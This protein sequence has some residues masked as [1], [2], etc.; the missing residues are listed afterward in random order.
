[1]SLIDP[2]VREP[3]EW[4]SQGEDSDP[5]VM[6]SRVRLARNLEKH[7]FPARADEEILVRIR[8]EVTG[9]ARSIPMLEGAVEAPLE[10]LDKVERQVLVER[11]LISREHAERGRGSAVVVRPDETVSLMINEEDHIRMQSLRGGLALRSAWESIR[12][13]DDALEERLIF[14]FS[15]RLGYLTACPTNVGTGLRASV[16]L[17]LPGLVMNGEMVQVIQAVAKLGLAVR[18]LYGEGT[19]AHGNLFQVS[20]QVTLGESEEE[21][22]DHLE[23]VIAQILESERHARERLLEKRKA[24]IYDQVGRAIGTLLNA[25]I[26]NSQE[27]TNL[28]SA[29]RLGVDLGLVEG[30]GRGT[31]DELFIA[32]QPAHLQYTAGRSIGASRRDQRRANLV[33]TRLRELGVRFTR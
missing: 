11:H 21:I 22:I 3:G 15:T 31:I 32:T 20:N 33:R 27:M 24:V 10:D 4:M 5:L 6:S 9:A 1:M 7:P 23:K 28:L 30:I 14:A 13:V 26:V 17:H 8:E 29:L 12:A 18:G 2:L 19:E 16:M 25:F